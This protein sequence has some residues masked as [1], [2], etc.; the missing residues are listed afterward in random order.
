MATRGTDLNAQIQSAMKVAMKAREKKKLGVIRLM[1]AAIKQREIDERVSLDD[2]EVIVVLDKM[3]K[4]RRDS[5]KQYRTAHRE[6]LADVEE[7]EIGVIQE[8]L[9]KPLTPDEI[10]NMIKAAVEQSGAGSVKDMGKVMGL[11]KPLMQGRVDLAG[12]GQEVKNFLNSQ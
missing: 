1:M 10:S 11:L 9:P 5:V 2:N 7:Y 3:V 6:D 12:V 4:Q 8:Y